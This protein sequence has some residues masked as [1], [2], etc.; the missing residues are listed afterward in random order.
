MA[1]GLP[2]LADDSGLRVKALGGAPGVRSARYGGKGLTPAERNAYLL[3]KLKGATDRRAY[4]KTELVLARPNPTK[5]LAWGGKV[6]GEIALAP[7]GGGGF[8]YDPVFFLP[9][10]SLTMAELPP[11]R[12]NALSHRGRAVALML[13]QRGKIYKYLKYK[14]SL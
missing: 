6:T 1:L 2:C 14:E 7:K 13:G 9:K 3:E 5:M 10:L 11:E 4:F 12:K 8:G